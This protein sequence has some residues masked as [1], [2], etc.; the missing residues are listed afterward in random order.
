MDVHRPDHIHHVLVIIIT[1]DDIYHNDDRDEL[2]SVL[3]VIYHQIPKPQD[4]V[5][6]N[7]KPLRTN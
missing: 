1:I 2:E 5:E 7:A 6:Y 3:T 4:D